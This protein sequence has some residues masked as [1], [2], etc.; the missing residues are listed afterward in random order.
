MWINITK[1]RNSFSLFSNSNAMCIEYIRFMNFIRKFVYYSNLSTQ[2]YAVMTGPKMDLRACE[3]HV[4][5]I[6]INTLIPNAPHEAITLILE[7]LKWDPV[8]RPTAKK[9]VQ[10]DFFKDLRLK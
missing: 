10:N 8:K 1:R 6:D 7:C 5:K 2:L 4:K 9:L 3:W